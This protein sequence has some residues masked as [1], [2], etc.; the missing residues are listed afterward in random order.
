MRDTDHPVERGAF[1][2]RNNL[3]YELTS[4]VRKK[5]GRKE[6]EKRK[7]RERNEK[8]KRKKRERKEMTV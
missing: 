1:T 6:K 7:K 5:R 4:T 8:E 3:K 2:R